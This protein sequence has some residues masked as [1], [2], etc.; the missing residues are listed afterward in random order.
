MNSSAPR[1]YPGRR[2]PDLAENENDDC[3][4][5]ERDGDRRL[6]RPP[7]YERDVDVEPVVEHAPSR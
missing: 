1:E 3:D 2:S 5:G 4:R 7:V 6:R